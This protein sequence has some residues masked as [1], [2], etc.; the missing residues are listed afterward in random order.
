MSKIKKHS[1]LRLSQKQTTEDKLKQ[2]IGS[3]VAPMIAKKSRQELETYAIKQLDTLGKQFEANHELTNQLEEHNAKRIAANE[4]RRRGKLKK[5]EPA[6]VATTNV[7][8]Q[9][10]KALGKNPT[11]KKQLIPELQRQFPD[12]F[13]NISALTIKSWLSDL[14]QGK[15]I[16]DGS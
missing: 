12:L 11:L 5:F 13:K 4:A 3:L 10:K 2:G 6:K 15:K 16:K 8:A 9:L 1:G 7:H 14:N